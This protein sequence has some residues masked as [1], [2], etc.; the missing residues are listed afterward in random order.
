MASSKVGL[1]L[2]A[3]VAGAAALFV[4][5]KKSNAASATPPGFTPPPGAQTTVLAPGGNNPLPFSVTRTAWRLPGDLGVTN[6]LYK[7]GSPT[8]FAVV[9][10]PDAAGQQIGVLAV[11]TSQTSGLLAQAAV[12]GF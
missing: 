12:A 8:D 10:K 3:L 4:F 7:T 11:G 1:L 2:G 5:E 6:M 9:M